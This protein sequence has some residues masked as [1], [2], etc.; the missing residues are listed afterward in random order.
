[1]DIASLIGIIAAFGIIGTAIMI[2]GPFMIFVNIPSILVVVGGTF[3]ATLIRVTLADFLGSFKIGMK[4]FMY[5]TDNPLDLIEE[6][7]EMASIAR[8]EGLLAL[9]TAYSI[10]RKWKPVSS[11]LISDPLICIRHFV[12]WSICSV[13]KQS[14]SRSNS[15]YISMRRFLTSS[16]AINT[17]SVKFW[18]I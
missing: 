14:K 15:R 4:A 10:S 6:A 2:G 7:V 1:M 17:D 13:P 11:S 18:S 12:T 8:K 3:G 16:K 9:S 5:K